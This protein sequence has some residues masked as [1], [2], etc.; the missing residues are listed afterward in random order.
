MHANVAVVGAQQATSLHASSA[1][2]P[3]DPLEVLGIQ[4]G[5]DQIDQDGEA[6]EP[7]DQ[8]LGVHLSPCPFRPLCRLEMH[9]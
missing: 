4:E 3:G 5:V 6:D 2:M 9:R 7:Y 1:R 8:V